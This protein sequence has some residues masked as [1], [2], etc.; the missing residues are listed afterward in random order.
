MSSPIMV[1]DHA[2]RFSQGD[3]PFHNPVNTAAFTTVGVL[4]GSLPILEIYHD[5]DGDWQFLCGT[6]TATEDG[7]LICMGC[8]Y[9]R[10][11]EM[12]AFADLPPGWM[13]F[14]ESER[15]PWQRSAYVPSEDEDDGNP[16]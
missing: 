5:H 10:F 1:E 15:D 4:D 11:P 2:H 12:G 13:A 16:S 14:R 3:W 8:V 7:R 6:T 9:E